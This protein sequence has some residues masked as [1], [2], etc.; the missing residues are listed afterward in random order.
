MSARHPLPHGHVPS[1][2]LGWAAAFTL[3][4]MLVVL[5]IIGIL[6]AM[7]LPALAR[8]REE[9]RR[10]AC[11]NNLD[12]IGKSL[13]IYCNNC[14]D[15]LPSWPSYGVEA[16]TV[17][18]TP[19]A[20]YQPTLCYV[21]D[22]SDPNR[23]PHEGGSRH[24]VVGYGF[25]YPRTLPVPISD[26]S[27]GSQNFMP[28]GLG[29]L[30]LRND[31]PDQHVFDCPSMRGAVPTYY[32]W[33]TQ[34]GNW[35]GN[36][37]EYNSG[38]W[39]FLGTKAGRQVFIG[40]GRGLR[41]TPTNAF[42]DGPSDPKVAAL[43]SS[44]SYRDA[45]FYRYD[46]NSYALPGTKPQVTAEFMT[47]PFKTRRI[48]KERAIASDTFDYAAPDARIS[49]YFTASGGLVN[50]HHKDAFNVLYGD[51][52]SKLYSD[53]DSKIKDW[54][55]DWGGYFSWADPSHLDTDNLTISSPTS[56][57]V[58]NLFDRAAGI[59]VE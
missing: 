29:I 3:I 31:L 19:G 12:Q 39:K 10:T 44:Y 17:R 32:G 59:D 26:L 1:L 34:S 22:P 51:G 25:E 28:V 5:A 20:P 16:C 55:M 33:S 18:T 57:R 13:S 58:W 56:H 6:A 42:I 24:M 11:M 53:A 36:R 7:I 45:P 47:P 46:G 48:L 37:Y 38:V 21:G 35:K 15:Y 9:G 30:V 54:G 14:D 43:L 41:S 52:H 27:P 40:D 2:A 49:D 8:A 4:E 23:P 50:S